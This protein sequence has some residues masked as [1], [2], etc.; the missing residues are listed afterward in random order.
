M[1]IRACDFFYGLID[2]GRNTCGMI[3]ADKGFVTNIVK[4]HFCAV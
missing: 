2:R 4:T 3:I 1:E